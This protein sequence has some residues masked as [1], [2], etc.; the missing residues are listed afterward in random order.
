MK[1]RVRRCLYRISSPF[2]AML[3][4]PL[5]LTLAGCGGAKSATLPSDPPPA[6]PT[7]TVAAAPAS[8]TSGASSMLT[9]SAANATQVTVTGSDGSSY[10]LSANGGT[11]AVSPAATATYTANATGTGGKASAAATVTV[12]AAPPAPTVT[13][14]AN[15]TSIGSGGS[16][17]LTV[18]ATNATAVTVTGSDGSTYNLPAT[19]GTQKVGP[20]ATTTYT[21]KATGSGGNASAT[22]VVTVSKSIV[23]HCDDCCQPNLDHGWRIIHLNR[24]RDECD[25]RVAERLGREQLQAGGKGRHAE[26][27]SHFYDDVYSGGHWSLRECLGHRHGDRNCIRRHASHQSRHLHAAGESHLRQLLRHAQ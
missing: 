27:H 20:A 7:V 9:V 19:G 13:I 25:S 21:A 23:H 14:A 16:S 12:T 26:S 24:H 10:N 15:P 8:I 1:T 18:A 11:Q 22:A 17:T 5:F 6:T 2:A 4:F 3:L